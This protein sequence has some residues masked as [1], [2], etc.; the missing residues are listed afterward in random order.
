MKITENSIYRKLRKEKDCKKEKELNKKEKRK[1]CKKWNQYGK[2]IS[3]LIGIKLK[4][5]K[6]LGNYGLK[7]FLLLLEAKFGFMLLVIEIQYQR[8]FT[9]LWQIKGES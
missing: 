1:E 7:A 4:E 6:E 2:M 5:L 9:T 8:I 3:Y